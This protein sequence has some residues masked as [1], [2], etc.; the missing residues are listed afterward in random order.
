ME[1]KS[2]KDYG[3][4]ACKLSTVVQYLCFSFEF[5]DS[6]YVELIYVDYLFHYYCTK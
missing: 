4:Y 5:I 1:E 2:F 3:K 6:F